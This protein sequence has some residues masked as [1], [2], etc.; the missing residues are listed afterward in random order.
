MVVEDGSCAVVEKAGEVVYLALLSMVSVS[1]FM[2][3]C[4]SEFLQQKI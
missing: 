2:S 4:L 3:V 1:V